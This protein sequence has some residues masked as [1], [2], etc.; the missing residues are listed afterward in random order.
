ME[1]MRCIH[2]YLRTVLC[3]LV[4]EALFPEVAA[5]IILSWRVP[6]FFGSMTLID[7]KLVG[8]LGKAIGIVKYQI[9]PWKMLHRNSCKNN[10]KLWEIWTYILR[11]GKK[12][13]VLRRLEQP[14]M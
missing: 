9:L 2:L 1:A 11:R 3:R 4:M 14:T 6:G 10:F 12:K 5:I 8:L 13:L 7:P